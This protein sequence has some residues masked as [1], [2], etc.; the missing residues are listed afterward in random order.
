VAI[1][2]SNK[3]ALAHEVAF[4]NSKAFAHKFREVRTITQLLFQ[5][6]ES[7]PSYLKGTRA[8]SKP[9]KRVDDD[10]ARIRSH[11]SNLLIP[12]A[13]LSRCGA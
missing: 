7:D 10:L 13:L 3:Q 9:F 2:P 12:R 8:I 6:Y 5:D 11:M 4:G 1:C